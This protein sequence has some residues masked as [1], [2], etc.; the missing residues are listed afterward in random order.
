MFIGKCIKDAVATN[1]LT[2]MREDKNL[3]LAITVHG[4]RATLQLR[5]ADLSLPSH[6]EYG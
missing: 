5:T 3:I 2:Q 6:D 4:R 1:K